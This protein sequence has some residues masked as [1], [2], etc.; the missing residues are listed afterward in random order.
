MTK[1]FDPK[2]NSTV[3]YTSR[4]HSGSGKIVKIEPTSRGP[5]F[6]VRD[7][8]QLAFVRLRATALSKVAL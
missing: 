7:D 4:A 1:P 2:L 3:N 8:T 5:F 6:V